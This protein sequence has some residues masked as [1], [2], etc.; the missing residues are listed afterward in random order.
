MEQSQGLL[1]PTRDHVTGSISL[2]DRDYR[3]AT[4]KHP[5]DRPRESYSRH[6]SPTSYLTS[7]LSSPLF[8][9][10]IY[11]ITEGTVFVGLTDRSTSVSSPRISQRDRLDKEGRERSESW[12]KGS[13]QL[14]SRGQCFR[15]KPIQVPKLESHRERRPVLWVEGRV[16]GEKC[17][18]SRRCRV[19]IHDQV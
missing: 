11:K 15:E 4:Q 2:V 19:P 6:P 16:G 7:L 5:V 10:S 14:G 1:R 9:A 8:S 3:N 17:S 12:G 13:R 18:C